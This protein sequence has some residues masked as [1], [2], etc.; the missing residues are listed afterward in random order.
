VLERARQTAL[1]DRLS[2]Y[3]VLHQFV[4]FA[5]VGTL[6]VVLYLLAFNVL[7]AL[8][9]HTLVSNGV[10]FVVSSIN[11][12]VLNKTW[13][14]KDR[15]RDAVVRQYFVFVFFTFVGLAINTGVL[16]LLLIPLGRFGTLGKN[17]AAIGAIPFSVVW[18]FNAYRRWTFRART[19][20]AGVAS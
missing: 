16:S 13:A 15:S 19:P 20:P 12:F 11:S 4:R 2:R 14:F 1:Y 10:A 17:A 18:N 7:L 9:L 6:N 8:G 3:P 5:T